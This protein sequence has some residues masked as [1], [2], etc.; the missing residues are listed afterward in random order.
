MLISRWDA[1]A[2]ITPFLEELT[3]EQIRALP[4]VVA[5]HRDIC[6][7]ITDDSPDDYQD[8]LEAVETIF[9]PVEHPELLN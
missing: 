7:E 4:R 2:E 1:I 5:L 9:N 8:E 3:V 6:R